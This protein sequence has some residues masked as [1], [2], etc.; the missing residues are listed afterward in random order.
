MKLV[1]PILLLATAVAVR[2][3][4]SGHGG[5]PESPTAITNF[6]PFV[7]ALPIPPV[8]KPVG[9]SDG[10]PVYEMP[11]V[12]VMH[13]F[14]RDLPE[15]PVWGYAG[16]YP[17]P[18]LVALANQPIY[19]RWINLLPKEYPAWLPADT[20]NHGVHGNL[21]QNVVHL[22][23]G[24]NQP[25]FDG[26]PTNWFRPGEHRTY[27][28]DNIDLSGDHE[29]LWY[30]DH[31][32]GVTANNVYAG[33]TGFYLLR[34]PAVE[35]PLNLPKDAYDIPL[36]FQDRDIQTNTSPATL[37]SVGVP[38]WHYLPVVNGK[39]AP[40]LEVE[41][42]RY[43]F[44]ILNGCGFRTLGLALL[45]DGDSYPMHQIATDDGFLPVPVRIALSNAPL[46]TLRMMPGERA[47]VVV[48]FS[49]LT[50]GTQLVF[51]NSFDTNSKA[52]QTSG[53]VNVVGGAF[54]QF[55]VQKKDPTPDTSQIPSVLVTNQVV[56]ADLAKRAVRTRTITLD[57]ANENPFPGLVFSRDPN[58]FAS[59]NM[60]RFMDPVTE[61]PRAG[62]VEIWQFVNLS[63]EAH[64]MHIHLL[65]FYVLDRTRFGADN[66]QSANNA[67]NY[68]SDRLLGKLKPLASYV[69][70]QTNPALANELGP[71]DVVRCA[72]L[73]VTRVVME[74]P[75]Q[76][77]FRGP[78]VYHCHILDHED[79]DMM[80]PLEVLD[81]LLPGQVQIG[82]DELTGQPEIQVGTAL[83]TSYLVEQGDDLGKL[84]A[85]PGPDLLGTGM[86][87]Y[88]TEPA[89]DPQRFYRISP[90][91]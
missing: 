49:G 18:T 1:L 76:P 81:P 26:H 69:A 32:I 79:N 64:P 13:R 48:D 23:G 31:A 17:G 74:W 87:R 91:P 44:R 10:T 60:R 61:T 36:A 15:V 90:R 59:L 56:A 20:N 27:Y 7:D 19:V 54:L 37:L 34:N 84:M 46:P 6:V 80:R 51:T 62:D 82:M 88:L 22:H 14:H 25:Q 12:E 57:L 28:Y 29:T 89:T 45:K 68:I 47:E 21:V 33:L 58:L 16:M 43:R 83:G 52:Q 4:H 41:P 8:A 71:K 65:D 53:P 73:A 63:S 40:Y 78:Y 72:P 86:T 42:R 50:N 38:P 3:G 24:A 66:Q 85:R 30:H 70:G 39:I 77:Q 35:D 5:D 9:F 67:S 2:A 55:R 11:M 75:T